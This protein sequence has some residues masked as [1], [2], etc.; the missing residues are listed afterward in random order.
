M[1]VTLHLSLYELLNQ[2]VHAKCPNET[3]TTKRW[4]VWLIFLLLQSCL[5]HL[6]HSDSMWVS[7]CLLLSTFLSLLFPWLPPEDQNVQRELTVQVVKSFIFISTQYNKCLCLYLTVLSL[8]L[9]KIC[10]FKMNG[11]NFQHQFKFLAEGVPFSI[12]EIIPP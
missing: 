12:F 6:Y 10:V 2:T 4:L 9:L 1:S 5:Q 11:E 8:Y 7:G 3:L